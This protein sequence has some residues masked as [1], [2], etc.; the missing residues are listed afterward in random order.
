MLSEYSVPFEQSD[1][2]NSTSDQ[3]YYPAGKHHSETARSKPCESFDNPE[4]D[5]SSDPGDAM[6][7]VILVRVSELDAPAVEKHLC[8]AIEGQE[9]EEDLKGGVQ[10]Q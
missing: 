6:K 8:E 2:E 3:T 1:H 5:A 10:N 4:F 9:K 7:E